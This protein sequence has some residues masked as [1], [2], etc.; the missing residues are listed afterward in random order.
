MRRTL[1]V[2][3]VGGAWLLA[4]LPAGAQGTAQLPL[5]S[6][7]GYPPQQVLPSPFRCADFTRNGDG[8]WSPL[9]P[10]AIRSGDTK[11]TLE[12]GVSVTPGTTYG[13]VDVAAVLNRRCVPH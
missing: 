10:I 9:R 13:G 12:P 5:T 2:A 8:T 4:A 1:I 7:A 6:A 11:A 3:F